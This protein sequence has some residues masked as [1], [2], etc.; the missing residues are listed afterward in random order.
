[1]KPSLAS[2][3]L[4]GILATTIYVTPAFADVAP[5]LGYVEQCTVAIQQGPG[6]SCIAC[7]SSYLTFAGDAA[8]CQSQYEGAGYAKACKSYGASVWTEV[9]CRADADAG[10]VAVTT[11]PGGC[12]CSLVTANSS[13][14]AAAF[15]AVGSLLLLGLRVRRQGR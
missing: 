6:K 11:P 10:N 1:M 13:H 5:P 4:L 7:P 2:S 15:L 9:W 12:S 14:R 8:T 3:L